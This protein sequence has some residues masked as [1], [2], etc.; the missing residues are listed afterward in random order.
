MKKYNFLSDY[1]EGCHPNILKALEKTNLE[2][3]LGY[4]EDK[5]SLRAKE[6][7]K[8]KMENSTVDI[9]F[10]SGGTQVNL[11]VASSILKPYESVITASSSHIVNNEAG[12]IEMTGHKVNTIHTD[13]GKITKEDIHIVL[14]NHMSYPHTVKP[15]IVYISNAT[16]MGTIYDKQELKQLYTFCKE[17]EL[18]LFLDGARIG[19]ALCNKESMLTLR[20]ISKYTDIFYIGATKNG[21]LLGE[22]IVVNNDKLKKNF[23]V[24]IKQRGA[25][26]A[27][28]RLLGIQFIELFKEDLFYHLAMHANL[29]STKI[30]NNLK[31][32]GYS[33]LTDA[34]S[35]LLF[36]I[37]PIKLIELLEKKYSFYR[38]KV[39]DK[40]Y[41]VIRL[42]TSWA[43]EEKNVDDF[44]NDIQEFNNECLKEN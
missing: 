41:L 4:G 1:N 31:E 30:R 36:P 22:A 13:T 8:K 10:I 38:W 37:L 5:Y 3:Q 26:L 16:E 44:I 24:N 25:L 9:Y 6:L 29:M 34:N 33:L 18:Y 32:L 23:V 21:A 17:K 28:G 42:V 14:N 2:P 39:I 20:D 12:A 7:L 11:I 19:N 27:K 15:K 35:N 43:T 40:E